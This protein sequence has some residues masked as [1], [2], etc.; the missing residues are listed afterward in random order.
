M[1]DRDFSPTGLRRIVLPRP[2]LER[3]IRDLLRRPERVLWT[4]AGVNQTA[5]FSEL[6]CREFRPGWPPHTSTSPMAFLTFQET[7][8]SHEITDR[9]LLQWRTRGGR[10]DAAILLSIYREGGAIGLTASSLLSSGKIEPVQSVLFPGQGMHRIMIAEGKTVLSEPEPS[11]EERE[12]WSRMIGA[13]GESE[14][15]RLRDVRY[16]VVGVGR[17]GSLIAA[18]LA[19]SGA[20]YVTLI[21]P[22][23]LERHNLDSMEGVAEEDVGKPKVAAMKERLASLGHASCQ[24]TTLPFSITSLGALIAVKESDLLICCADHDGARLA[25]GTLANLY[26]K[27]LL[28]IGTGIH[29]A[30]EQ[31]R[32]GADVRLILPGDRC[33][34]CLG[35]VANAEQAREIFTSGPHPVRTWHAQRAGSLRSLNQVAAH[36][37]LRLIEDL[38]GVRVR[39]STWVHLEFDT[40][41]TPTLADR[42]GANDPGCL[43][44]RHGGEGDAGIG[45][46]RRILSQWTTG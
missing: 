43:L 28:D 22:D 1:T 44:C 29:R 8:W 12:R 24:V 5:D 19:R 41:G 42:R 25:T 3:G 31:R 11:A 16:C 6:I 23:R 10:W 17:T 33:L 20:R 45:T 26:Y 14:W 7:R 38:V 39:R 40:Q 2:I 9:T 35:G 46:V 4:E 18:S 13:L 32:V 30:G 15:R 34:L 21:D 27:P 36:L 37:G